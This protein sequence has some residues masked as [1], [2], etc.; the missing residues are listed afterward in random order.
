MKTLDH[1]RRVALLML[2]ALVL[3]GWLAT[4]TEVFYAD[5][6]RYIRQAKMLDQGAWNRG[7]FQ[8]VDHPV[9]PLAITAGH[10]LLGGNQP[11]DWQWA[12]QFAAVVA[13]VLVIIP[14]YLIAIELIGP[15]A[16]WLP[17]FLIYA[18]PLHVHVMADTLSESWYLLFWS[19]AVWTTLRFVK[20]ARLAWLAPVIGFSVLAYLTRPEGLIVP[21]SLL[22]TLGV[23]WLRPHLEFPRFAR[24]AAIA[25]LFLGPILAA[26]PFIIAKG[27]ISTKPSLKRVLSLTSRAPAMAIERERPGDPDQPRYMALLLATKAMMRSVQGAATLPI[28]VL[29]PIGIAVSR[30]TNERRR[31]WMLVAIMVTLSLLSMIRLHET[32]GYC[33]PR[34]AMMV[35]WLAIIAGAAGIGPAGNFLGK[36]IVRIAAGRAWAGRLSSLLQPA[37][38]AG[39]LFTWLPATTAPM[40]RCFIGYRQAGEWLAAQAGPNEAVIDPKGFSLFYAGRTGYTFATLGEGL[41][42]RRVRWLVTHDAHLNGPWDYSKLVRGL[43]GDRRPMRTFPETAERGIARVYVYD[44]TQPLDRTAAQVGDSTQTLH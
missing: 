35:G 18:M 24:Y 10:R 15:S 37:F 20:T 29:A 19:L 27:G 12:A 8:A 21:V 5:G 4:R 40:D 41:N 11:V 3:L 22:A 26:G 2:G 33:T 1:V 6:L 44:L 34:H 43:S 39:C 32:S 31:A 30:P 36:L 23:F 42:D 25:V 13:G 38:L 28:L 14:I 7:L 16:A 9:Y 17:C